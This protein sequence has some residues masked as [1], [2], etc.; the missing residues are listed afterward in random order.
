MQ[1]IALLA[2][3]S[4]LIRQKASPNVSTIADGMK[5]A[6][7][8]PAKAFPRIFRDHIVNVM[9]RLAGI[10]AQSILRIAA[11]GTRDAAANRIRGCAIKKHVGRQNARANSRLRTADE[12]YWRP[13][14]LGVMNERSR[15]RICAG[16]DR[17]AEARTAGAVICS[18]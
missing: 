2:R 11:S 15:Y 3:W 1:R 7:H 10:L 14:R 4:I 12:D 8:E 13:M 5:P 6:T 17:M 9:D 16:L 18:A